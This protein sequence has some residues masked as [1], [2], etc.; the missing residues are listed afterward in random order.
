MRG[1]SFLLRC[2]VASIVIGSRI[3][4][5]LTATTRQGRQTPYRNSLLG[6]CS[7]L[8]STA[9]TKE[10]TTSI[11]NV[12]FKDWITDAPHEVREWASLM[13][14]EGSIP[15]YVEG[16]LI[17]NGPGVWSPQ[18]ENESDDSY[19]HIFDGLAKISA[20]RISSK[21]SRSDDN[22]QEKNQGQAQVL[23][24]NEFIRSEWYQ[25]MQNQQGLPPSISTGPIISAQTKEPKAGL[26]RMMGAIL[27][28]FKFDNAPV[29]VWDFGN[30][31]EVCALTDAPP[32]AI[33]S[34]DDMQ[35][36]ATMTAPPSAHGASGYELL[37]TAHPE[38][39]KG[40]GDEGVPFQ[41]SSYNV[42]V[43]LGWRGARIN[44]VQE[45]SNGNR[46]VVGQSAPI[47]DGVPYLHSFGVSSKHAIVVLQPFRVDLANFPKLM[48]VGFLRGMKQ[49]EQTRILVF[50]LVTGECVAETAVKDQ[51]FFYHSISTAEV[52]D[53]ISIRL[54]AYKVPD[55]VSGED[56]FMRLERCQE[57]KEW[58]NRISKGGTFC[59][60]VCN[61]KNG[62]ARVE[63]NDKIDQGFE[64]PTTRYS[65]AFGSD[66]LDD[67]H[68][69]YVYAFGS[70]ACGSEEYDAWGLFKYDT[71]DN[72][73]SSFYRHDS[74][75]PSEPIFVADPDGSNEDDGVIL[76]Q[77]YDGNRRE[78]AL[79]VLDAA[80]MEK[81]ACI[82]TGQRSPMDFHGTWVPAK[83][84]IASFDR[85]D[86][87]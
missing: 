10:S 2:T 84:M 78:T 59:D 31:S 57:S 3:V 86:S 64:L 9:T 74:V 14:Q 82:W 11:A 49:V 45:F 42:A 47:D 66:A 87:R 23:Y 52:D 4:E 30:E 24:R 43:E 65:R 29:N 26:G 32:R 7:A 12:N 17:R 39:A 81:L 1:F 41:K 8:Q 61:L 69:R 22:A 67:K 70:Y 35:T 58:R 38:Y 13:D 20:Y 18:S 76:S 40:R 73:V 16:T 25:M 77:I 19:S 53:E 71:E 50:D 83:K 60:V 21:T 5:A 44:L 68:P 62:K 27:N 6:T 33:L 36:E 34:L 55:I 85:G 80:T 28:T 79:L 15:P 56:Q 46:R 75:Y 48:E 51:V 72:C 37:L 63:W 54:C